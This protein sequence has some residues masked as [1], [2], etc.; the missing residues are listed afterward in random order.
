MHRAIPKVPKTVGQQTRSFGAPRTHYP[1]WDTGM[2]VAFAFHNCFRLAPNEKQAPHSAG[3]NLYTNIFEHVKD[4]R[5]IRGNPKLDAYVAEKLPSVH[6]KTDLAWAHAGDPHKRIGFSHYE[7]IHYDWL[8]EPT[9][10]RTPNLEAGEV[11]TGAQLHRTDVW[12]TPDEP[13]IISIG[14]FS[15]DNFRADGYAENAP[16]PAYATPLEQLDF[17]HNRLPIG[18][19]DRR[20]WIYFCGSIGM[21]WLAAVVRGVIYRAVYTLWPAKDVFAAGTIEVDLRQIRMGQNFV[22]KF[23]GKPIFIRRRSPEDIA[24]A[25]RD[26]AL[27]TSMRDPQLD[28]DRAPNPEWLI[29]MGV[30]THLGC[31]PFP[32][33]GD[34]GGY[35]CPCHGS[36]YDLS[37]RCR[38]GPAGANMSVPPYQF[39]DDFTVK[40]G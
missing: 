20:P 6:T 33:S 30:C 16:C 32:D 40:V 28:A 5:E 37:G 36:H 14:R 12:K 23:R 29:I 9:F 31:I 26:D 4:A 3:N 35:F 17:R 18:H 34:W 11:A 24:A 38:K 19:S 25:K 7:Y 1:Q 27:L 39:L 21:M 10:P 22:T 15:P 2:P 13:A 8:P